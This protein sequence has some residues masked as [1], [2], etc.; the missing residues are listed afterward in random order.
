[1][2]NSW[3]DNTVTPFHPPYCPPGAEYLDMRYHEEDLK[4]V[5]YV[6]ETR[7]GKLEP[8]GTAFSTQLIVNHDEVGTHSF[9]YW[10]TAAHLIN[11]ISNSPILRINRR[12]TEPRIFETHKSDWIFNSDSDVAVLPFMV[13]DE[14]FAELDLEH[15][16]IQNSI[17]GKYEYPPKEGIPS[18]NKLPDVGIG[19]DVIM[20]GLFSQLPGR[21]KNL[22]IGRFGNIA[23]MPTE[24]KI[25]I[26]IDAA[27]TKRNIVAYLIEGKSWGGQSG[28]PVLCH[29]EF[30]FKLKKK[31]GGPEKETKRRITALMGLVSCHFDV[32]KRAKTGGIIT[33]L[34][35]GIAAVVPSHAI[36]DLI[37]GEQ[38]LNELR[39][40]KYE[41]SRAAQPT[42]TMDSV[43]ERTSGQGENPMHREDFNRLLGAAVKD[44]KPSD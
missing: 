10:V 9:Y 2:M 43:H 20:L 38:K 18:T 21:T 33:G 4:C 37:M 19:D 6:C 27:P 40:Q 35:S 34:N 29:A 41:Q 44:R 16:N 11:N 39:D 24:E 28:S 3:A 36:K 17:T 32:E 42:A 1:M 23:R 25:T 31:E 15:I 14:E 22:P 5:A 30:T 26:D 8:V 13:P 12:Q 7:G